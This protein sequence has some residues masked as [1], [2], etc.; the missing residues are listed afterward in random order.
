MFFPDASVIFVLSSHSK[1]SVAWDSLN[2]ADTEAAPNQ[3]E[4][5]VTQPIKVEPLQN[6][7]IKSEEVVLKPRLHLL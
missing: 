6:L 5:G 3:S 2:P 1:G 4:A 7:I